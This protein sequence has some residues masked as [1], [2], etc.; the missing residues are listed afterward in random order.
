V[1]LPHLSHR[2]SL[3]VFI[4]I[5]VAWFSGILI[6]DFYRTGS[7][8]QP[9]GYIGVVIDP[10]HP[11][12]Q[13]T[14]QWVNERT[15]TIIDEEI[16]RALPQRNKETPTLYR[17]RSR[18]HTT[19]AYLRRTTSAELKAVADGL[20]Q[21]LRNRPFLQTPFY[22]SSQL[23]L[24]GLEE[25]IIVMTLHDPNQ[26]LHMLHPYIEATLAH[27]SNQQQTIL[28]TPWE[29][30]GEFVPHITLAKIETDALKTFVAEQGGDAEAVAYTIRERIGIEVLPRFV[31][32]DALREVPGNSFTLFDNMRQEYETFH[33]K[34]RE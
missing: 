15:Q 25:D 23:K 27:V 32:P 3:L 6:L 16:E 2:T 26:V 5:L 14:Q 11:G 4:F 34:E 33:L 10:Q 1:N 13:Y 24:F 21:M 12:V 22:L 29:T 8:L 9:T 7:A 18:C 31:I 30:I 19:L 28:Y 17:N 20:R